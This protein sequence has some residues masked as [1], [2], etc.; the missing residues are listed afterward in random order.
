LGEPSDKQK[1]VYDTVLRAQKAGI[2]AIRAGKI[3]AE[4]DEAAR[5]VIRQAG[6]GDCFGHGFGHGVGLEIH[7]EPRVSVSGKDGIP[8]GAVITAEPGVYLPGEFGV[9]IE[10]LL[11]VTEQVSRNLT[12]MAKDMRI[13][14]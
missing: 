7:E 13:I 6:Y 11:A 8:A 3:G 4:I 14:R 12:D 10:D 2:A 1:K 5:A 9:R